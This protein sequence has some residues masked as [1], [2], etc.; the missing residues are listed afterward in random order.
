[1]FSARRP[2]HNTR[3]IMATLPLLFLGL[4]A[5]R[6]Q[7]VPIGFD[8]YHST[9]ATFAYL[10]GVAAA[11]P[12]ITE[13]AEIGKSTLGRPIY[14]LVVSNMKTGTTLDA[15][16]QLRHPR[17]EGVKNV[18]PMKPYMGK[19]GQFVGGSTHGNE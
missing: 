17:E 13:L 3:F 10:K 9:T 16:I 7:K 18:T 11:Y 15:Q 6:A 4:G 5:P 19:P 14:V 2:R 1:M 12:A 8:D